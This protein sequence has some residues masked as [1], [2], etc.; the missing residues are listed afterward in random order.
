MLRARVLVSA[1][2][3]AL[4]PLS[5][6]G[7]TMMALTSSGLRCPAASFVDNSVVSYMPLNQCF[8]QPGS[9]GNPPTSMLVACGASMGGS[10]TVTATMYSDANCQHQ[11][12]T[13]PLVLKDNNQ[14]NA[15]P[16]GP[17]GTSLYFVDCSA[18]PSLPAFLQQIPLIALSPQS[19]NCPS[20]GSLLEH[21]QVALLK[22]NAH[23]N[24]SNKDAIP[25]MSDAYKLTFNSNYDATWSVCTMNTTI[26]MPYSSKCTNGLSQ[27]FPFAYQTIP[28]GSGSSGLS[29]GS[30]IGICFAV[31]AVLGGVYAFFFAA[32]CVSTR[33]EVMSHCCGP[34]E[35]LLH[36]DNGFS[37]LN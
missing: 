32:V 29:T 34:K 22:P 27:T 36:D 31:L 4:L 19:S 1:L 25:I 18:K 23:A 15:M 20:S 10:V 16:S 21:A 8:T 26:N 11:T 2:L 17:A 9:Q 3:I 14:C 6:A 35:V 5:H 28:P 37:S 13:Q 7:I 33:R 30:I 12:G 24:C